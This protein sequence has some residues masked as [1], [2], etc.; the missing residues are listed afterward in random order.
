MATVCLVLP[1][2]NQLSS[3]GVDRQDERNPIIDHTKSSVVDHHG[4]LYLIIDH[5][6]SRVVNRHGGLNSNNNK[7]T[8]Q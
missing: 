4:K 7:S 6:S 2:I 5:V 3:M 8:Q 1:I